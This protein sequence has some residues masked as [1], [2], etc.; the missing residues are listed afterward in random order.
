MQT[1][2]GSGKTMSE[3]VIGRSSTTTLNRTAGS[4]M[5]IMKHAFGTT[6]GTISSDGWLT[7]PIKVVSWPGFT[8]TCVVVGHTYSTSVSAMC[9]FDSV[10]PTISGEYNWNGEMVQI[11][12]TYSGPSIYAKGDSTGIY[13]LYAARSTITAGSSVSFSYDF[14]Y[15]AVGA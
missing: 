5:V 6:T 4:G 15:L 2:I 10:Y 14:V 13:V 1:N 12:S 9:V 8:A 7:N 11:K 3:A